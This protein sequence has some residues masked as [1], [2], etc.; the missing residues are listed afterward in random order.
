MSSTAAAEPIGLRPR[1][2]WSRTLVPYV[3]IGPTVVIVLA[4]MA[5]GLNGQNFTFHGYLP[6]DRTD[7]LKRLKELEAASF[8][9]NQT[10]IFME[11]PYH[12]DKLFEEIVT[13]C[14]PKTLLC[15]ASGLTGPEEFIK[16]CAI[17]KWRKGPAPSLDK[18]P[19]LFLLY[20]TPN[21]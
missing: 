10:Q 15:V 20:K 17:E 12:N 2:N 7:R 16:T 6:K 1:R 18:K 9:Q 13:T 14:E 5:S 19:T 21:K 3:L 8:R 4:L 11:T